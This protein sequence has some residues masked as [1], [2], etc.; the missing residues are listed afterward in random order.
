MQHLVEKSFQ[1]LQAHTTESRPEYRFLASAAEKDKQDLAVT[2][3]VL[4]KQP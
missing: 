4:G 2:G 3:L 1:N